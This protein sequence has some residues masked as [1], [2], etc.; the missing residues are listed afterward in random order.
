M[1]WEHFNKKYKKVGDVKTS[2]DESQVKK[3]LL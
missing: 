2:K 1:N 3:L